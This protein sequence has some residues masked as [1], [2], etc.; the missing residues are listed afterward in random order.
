MRSSRVTI[1]LL[2]LAVAAYFDLL[3]PQVISLLTLGTAVVVAYGVESV[4]TRLSD[5]E[6]YLL[7]RS[8]EDP[9]DDDQE[10]A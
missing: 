7:P 3:S 1:T 9:H 10:A 5:L 6:Q 4:E 2:V 8:P